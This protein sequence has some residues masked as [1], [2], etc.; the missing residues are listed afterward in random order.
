MNRRNF[1]KTTGIASTLALT[2]TQLFAETI[3]IAIGT[4]PFPEKKL[5]DPAIIKKICDRIKPITNEERAQ[6]L[7]QARKLM[8]ENKICYI[9]RLLSN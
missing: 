5:I 2:S 3:P 1:I 9:Q 6:R 4:K 8:S 7:E